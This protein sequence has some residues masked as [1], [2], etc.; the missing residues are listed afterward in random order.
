MSRFSREKLMLRQIS[1]FVLVV[2]ASPALAQESVT[3]ETIRLSKQDRNSLLAAP[4]NQM[5]LAPEPRLAAAIE[6]GEIDR[7]EVM[8]FETTLS[9]IEAREIG[10]ATVAN[11]QG[12]IYYSPLPLTDTRIYKPLIICGSGR[13]D[14]HDGICQD[15]SWI[16]LQ[17]DWMPRPIFFWGDL[18]DQDVKQVYD[19]IDELN[20]VSRTDGD[21]VTSDKIYSIR[22]FGLSESLYNVN[23]TTAKDGSTDAVF[24]ARTRL[25]NGR[26]E[27]ELSE[28]RCSGD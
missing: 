13:N 22:K 25:N 3:T 9:D 7:V 20:L 10:Q 1:R 24:L 26:S 4:L 5:N 11:Y 6:R 18:T 27:F 12:S 16:R 8:R 14:F 17:T 28:F 21:V 2:V 15:H 23:V 19:T